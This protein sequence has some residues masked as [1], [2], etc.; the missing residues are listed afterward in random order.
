QVGDEPLAYYLPLAV[1]LRLASDVDTQAWLARAYSLV[2]FGLTVAAAWAAAQELF[3]DDPFLAPATTAFVGMLPMAAYMGMAINNDVAAALVGTL[4]GGVLVRMTKEGPVAACVIALVCTA[5]AGL[6]VKKTAAYLLPL[7]GSVLLWAA[8]RHRRVWGSARQC[9]RVL[10]WVAVGVGVGVLALCLL[11][12]VPGPEPSAWLDGT[13]PGREGRVRAA[14]WEGRYGFQAVDDS[15][16][17]AERLVQE[18]PSAPLRGKE[19]TLSAMARSPQGTEVGR[20][21]LVPDQGEACRQVFQVGEVWREVQVRCRVPPEAQVLKVVLAAGPG[22]DPAE[23]GRVYVDAVRLWADGAPDL[24]RNGGAEEAATLGESFSVRWERALQVLRLWLGQ[25]TARKV[26]RWTEWLAA[27]PRALLEG[28]VAWGRLALYTVLTFAGFWGNFGWLTVPLSPGW[29]VLLS[30][31]TLGSAAGLVRWWVQGKGQPWQ[32]QA[33]AGLALALALALFQNLVPMLVRDWQPQ[34]RYLLPALFPAGALFAVG[35]RAWLPEAWARRGAA[36]F[37]ASFVVLNLV[38]LV[39]YV[40]P[41]F[42]N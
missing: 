36:V 5:L 7:T 26:R 21:A 9:R 30:L 18:V 32:R 24:L 15:P 2:L 23:R 38:C 31:A 35:W 16:T 20:L 40:I 12:R 33:C 8:W 34:G 6:W 1:L 4:Y 28:Q 37:V 13:L 22:E 19:V 10:A 11:A 42:H 17:L 25:G 27:V 41:Y 14:A 29:Y 39:G 3:P